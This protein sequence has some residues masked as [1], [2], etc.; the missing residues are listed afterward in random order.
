MWWKHLI[1]LGVGILLGIF[2]TLL[3]NKPPKQEIQYITTS[4]SD[5]VLKIV[6]SLNVELDYLRMEK[7]ELLEKIDTSKVKIK[8]IEKWYEKKRDIILTQPTDSDCM[9][10]SNY[11]S[12]KFK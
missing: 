7:A 4:N 9:F 10:F 8:V 2:T 5:S 12:E 11:L 1:S 3:C 6:D